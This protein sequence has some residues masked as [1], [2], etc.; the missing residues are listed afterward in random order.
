MKT[1]FLIT[2][3]AVGTSMVSCKKRKS[4]K[5]LE[6]LFT[7]SVTAAAY[8]DSTT[9]ILLEAN[10]VSFIDEKFSWNG[11]VVGD[12][13][14]ETK[15]VKDGSYDLEL[16][17]DNPDFSKM[18]PSRYEWDGNAYVNVISPNLSVLGTARFYVKVDDNKKLFF[19]IVTNQGETTYVFDKV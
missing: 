7:T 16:V 5:R 11:V 3:I 13:K 1:L 18:L 12:C 9:Q 15:K 4:E 2:I 19:T 17:L 14:Y 6:G 8:T 10:T